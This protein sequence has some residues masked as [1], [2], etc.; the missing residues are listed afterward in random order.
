MKTKKK[1]STKNMKGRQPGTAMKRGRFTGAALGRAIEDRG[2]TRD[3]MAELTGRVPNAIQVWIGRR[4]EKVP[5]W[6]D[7]FFDLYD[8]YVAARGVRS[9]DD[10]RIVAHLE[11]GGDGTIATVARALDI[12]DQIVDDRCDVLIASGRLE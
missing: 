12:P 9:D 4:R 6:F 1:R 11:Q 2:L 10:D 7:C 3:R 5:I 8:K